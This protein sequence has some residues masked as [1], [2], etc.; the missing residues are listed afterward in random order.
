[1][2]EAIGPGKPPRAWIN[3]L[4]A[5]EGGREERRGEVAVKNKRRLGRKTTGGRGNDGQ[6]KNAAAGGM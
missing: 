3:R 1:M 6:L 2:S 4:G 5:L